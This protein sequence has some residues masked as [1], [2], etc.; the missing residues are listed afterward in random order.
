MSY[1]VAII[2][3]GQAGLAMGYH[4]ARAGVRFTILDAGAAPA[5]AW[6]S[7][8]D[9]LR[10]FTPA[11]HDG[12]PGL[13]FPAHPD[14]YPGRDEVVAYLSDYARQ[15][16]LPVEL[17][18]R[19]TALR[20]DAA[21]GYRV[22]LADRTLRA[23]QVVVATGP[24]QTPRVPALARQL[25]S[26]V[27]Q[28]HS[29]DYRRPADLP[30]GRVL[31][32]GGGNTGFQ[33]AGE[34]ARSHDVHLAVGSRQMPLPQRILGRDLFDY[35]SATG[36][37][38]VTVN[39]RVGRRMQHRETLIGSSPRRAR[40]AGITLHPRAIQ[41]SGS[42]ISFADGAR[43]DVS[44]VLWATGYAR[45]YSWIDAPVFGAGGGIAHRRGVTAAPGL[46]FL[47]LPWQHTRGS[48]LLGWVGED[49]EYLAGR[50]GEFTR[51]TD[52]DAHARRLAS[53]GVA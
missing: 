25:A 44:T 3:G 22:E 13:P 28:L 45:D 52:A 35:L 34:L 38:Q 10:L 27:V 18:S 19:V 39:S 15:F 20:A 9:S 50:I 2:G 43:L 30:A 31:I 36:L 21:G 5:A 16:A 26:D 32:V 40:Q 51:T 53:E 23:D 29:S 49:A 41:A 14:H 37:L 17:D 24:F 6:R 1:E 48:A 8:W 42:S 47:G 4:L 33:I 11:R 7:R 46:Y 12:L